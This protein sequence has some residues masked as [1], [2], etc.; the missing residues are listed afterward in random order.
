[1]SPIR[2]SPETFER[3]VGEAIDTLPV[4]FKGRID[5]VLFVVED[6]PDPEVGL[7]DSEG[8]LGLYQGVPLTQRSV[9]QDE[10]G[11]PDV[12]T[13][14]QKNIEAICQSS[15]QVQ[16]QIAETVFHELGHYFG[17][18]EDEMDAIEAQWLDQS[19]PASGS[20]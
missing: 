16:R 19:P 7:E 10:P 5:N 20:P 18:D 14:Y 9:W 6:T 15:A 1:M 3:W 13:L 2:V 17:L 8:L 4:F 11:Y 12:I